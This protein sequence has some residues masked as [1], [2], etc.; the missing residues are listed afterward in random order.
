[1]IGAAAVTSPGRSLHAFVEIGPVEAEL[2]NH[3]VPVFAR[4]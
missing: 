4:E 1:M 2:R 3:A